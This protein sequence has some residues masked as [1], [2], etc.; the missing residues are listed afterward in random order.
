MRKYPLFLSVNCVFF[1]LLIISSGCRSSPPA[2][3]Y[4]LTALSGEAP[5]QQV[6]AARSHL[7][8]GIDPVDIPD[9]L[10]RHQIVTRSGLNELKLAEYDRWA[11]SLGED[12]TAVIAENLSLLLSA[13]S[14]FPYPWNSSSDIDY[15]IRI[16]VLRFEGHPGD[17][18][19]LK[20]RWTIAA[21]RENK[22][23]LT[24][25]SD[26]KEKLHDNGYAAMVSAM[27]RALETLS[28]EI[29][30]GIRKIRD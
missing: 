28:S 21:G 13:D 19:S 26:L 15:R 17:H 23:V 11:G 25:Q 6:P 10:D 27:S 1:V 24:Q 12:I 8:I 3:F 14:V 20:A 18:V 30:S 9:Y 2:K 5:T 16:H 22:E 7:S 4:T 29:A